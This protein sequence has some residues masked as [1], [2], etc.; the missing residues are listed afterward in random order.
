MGKYKIKNKGI[1]NDNNMI[2]MLTG[3]FII[4][5]YVLLSPFMVHSEKHQFIIHLIE[6][7]SVFL[8]LSPKSLLLHLGG[9]GRTPFAP[10]HFLFIKKSL[11]L[12]NPLNAEP[13]L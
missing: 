2:R 6:L 13:V 8:T 11:P 9:L 3:G 5:K 12:E 10:N 1:R 4:R 7:I